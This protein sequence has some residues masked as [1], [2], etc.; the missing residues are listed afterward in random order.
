MNGLHERGISKAG[1]HV[2]DDKAVCS[3]F[4]SL[5]VFR[6]SACS[7]HLLLCRPHLLLKGDSVCFYNRV[8]LMP[9]FLRLL[10]AVVVGKAKRVATWYNES[11]LS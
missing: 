11:N 2:D 6:T 4:F 3:L 7:F 1:T 8:A 9:S 10:L 5:D